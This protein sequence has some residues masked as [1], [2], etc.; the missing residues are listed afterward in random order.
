MASA[1]E[2]HAPVGL[3]GSQDANAVETS[4][5]H[6]APTAPEG[7]QG[8]DLG[9]PCTTEQD[10]ASTS[11]AVDAL[12]QEAEE[13]GAGGLAN[14]ELALATAPAHQTVGQLAQWD[15]EIRTAGRQRCA[16]ARQWPDNSL[17]THT[18]ARLT[19]P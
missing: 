6:E 18:C 10:R 2:E 16:A 7:N 8:A 1:V 15:D 4:C 12:P 3:E 13:S 9:V 5:E 19:R 17:A 14:D 11:E